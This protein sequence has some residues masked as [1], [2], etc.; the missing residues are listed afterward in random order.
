MKVKVVSAYVEL[1]TVNHSPEKFKQLGQRL[2]QAVGP[3]R[4]HVFDN[5]PFQDCWLA[6]W[7][8]G[9]PLPPPAS[10][11]PADRFASPEHMVMSN[12]V[13]H[14]KLQWALMAADMYPDCDCFVWLDY[15]ILKQGGWTGR[16]VT[17]ELITK[18]V[19]KIAADNIQDIPFPAIWGKGP[20][21]DTEI[22]WRFAGS[23]HIWPRKFLVELAGQ[24]NAEVMK[25]IMRTGTVPLDLPIWALLEQRNTLPFRGYSANH[26]ATQLTNYRDDIPLSP[27]CELAVK[28][29]TDKGPYH[30]YTQM[31]YEALRGRRESTKKVLEIGIGYIGKGY[32][33]FWPHGSSL[34]MWQEF[35]P[36]AHIFGMDIHPEVMINE[37]R[38]TSVV[39]DQS[40]VASLIDCAR[41]MGGAFDLIVDDGSHV[42][43]HAMLTAHVLLPFLAQDGIYVI[44]DMSDADTIHI[45]THLPKLPTCS[46]GDPYKYTTYASRSEP[47]HANMI[48]L[49]PDRSIF[50]HQV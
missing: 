19:D 27:L 20:V 29:E 45:L 43:E 42:V 46:L 50:H 25:F 34:R 44:E 17:E 16:P 18:F 33:A 49:H 12:I 22:P 32:P 36:N 14:Q 11:V 31:Y 40:S 13:M 15:G 48:L 35:F 7:L 3:E 39:G 30:G 6:Q 5:F 23:T 41:A 2:V 37:D 28:H 21:S 38:I 26:D 24:Y 10:Y 1:P 47:D 4:M 9:H 8:K